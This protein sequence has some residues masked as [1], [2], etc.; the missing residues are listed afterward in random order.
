[1][2]EPLPH[3]RAVQGAASF[4]D[5]AAANLLMRRLANLRAVYGVDSLKLVRDLPGGGKVVAVD[6]GGIRRTLIFKPGAQS[7]ELPEPPDGSLGLPMLFSGV[8]VTGVTEPGGK[9]EL[10]LTRTC[11]RRL[12]GYRVGASTIQAGGQG[13]GAIRFGSDSVPERVELSRFVVPYGAGFADLAPMQ[14]T[15]GSIYT[16]YH[17]QY[18]TW[19]SGAMAAVVQT[20]AGYGLQGLMLSGAP[21]SVPEYLEVAELRVPEPYRSRITEELRGDGALPGYKGRPPADGEIKYG[22]GWATTHAV[23]FDS[24]SKPWLLQVGPLGV[25]AMP[26]PVIPETTTRAFREY[27]EEVGDDEIL[28]LLDRFGGMPSGEPFPTGSDLQCWLRAGVVIKLCDT[29]DFYSHVGMTTAAGWAFADHGQGAHNTCLERHATLN[30]MDCHT[31]KMKLRLQ[32]IQAADRPPADWG[33]DTA[34]VMEYLS[35][36]KAALSGEP[37]LAVR[38]KLQ[39]VEA[40]LIHARAMAFAPERMVAEVDY[41]D[42]LEL[43]PLAGHSGSVTRTAS[44]PVWPH[45]IKFPEPLLDACINPDIRNML[46]PVPPGIY[47]YPERFDTI[48]WT[49]YV[50]SQLK[51]VRQA[52]DRRSFNQESEDDY[53]ECMIVGSWESTLYEGSQSIAGE[54]Y[55]TD[56]DYRE[57]LGGRRTHVRTEG[58]D[59]GYD[60]KPRAQI[61]QYKYLFYTYGGSLWRIRWYLHEVTTRVDTDQ[62][63]TLG[64]CVPFLSRNGLLWARHKTFGQKLESYGKSVGGVIDPTSYRIHSFKRMLAT[65]AQ[66]SNPADR[67]KD[68]YHDVVEELYNPGAC[69]DFADSGGWGMTGRQTGYIDSLLNSAPADC[70][71]VPP[72]EIGEV[73]GGGYCPRQDLRGWSTSQSNGYDSR[74]ELSMLDAAR[75]VSSSGIWSHYADASPDAGGGL[76]RVEATHNCCGD[77]VFLK[78]SDA[79]GKSWGNSLLSGARR[80]PFFI[81]VINE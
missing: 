72:F 76:F 25:H 26:L 21:A 69:S 47:H 34:R 67:R 81:G 59:L 40:T 49:Y 55:T 54:F 4:E 35:T 31:Y 75:L 37:G 52:R 45:T 12:A 18:P 17:Q 42:Q 24:E 78:V 77:A 6:A 74:L 29:A 10:A 66:V 57:V 44:G 62:A 36:L 33:G 60:S 1:M 8:A 32:A 13:T 7:A 16:Q 2:H 61:P 19:Y 43:P 70:G 23:G 68:D 20:V 64:G 22:F 5:E 48:I 3:G 63:L 50:G 15:P 46:D 14:P 73:W 39:R 58:R 30:R 27:M 38:F 80:M 71:W 41:W 51:V 65:G 56:F 79:G 11:R 9:I 53:E 28:H